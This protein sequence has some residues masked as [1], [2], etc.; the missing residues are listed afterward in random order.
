[1]NKDL[2]EAQRLLVLLKKDV[3]RARRRLDL[4]SK[5]SGPYYY[6]AI[7]FKVWR[8]LD[9]YEAELDYAQQV[10]CGKDVLPPEFFY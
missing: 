8:L 9:G 10:I 3:A 2:Q 7:H 5:L 1:M 4:I 6:D